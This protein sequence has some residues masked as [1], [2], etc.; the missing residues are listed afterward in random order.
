MSAG[1]AWEDECRAVSCPDQACKT[2]SC[3]RGECVEENK[4]DGIVRDGAVVGGTACDDGDSGTE[5]DV[6]SAGLLG[7]LALP[8]S[9]C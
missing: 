9:G 8:R 7:L 6:C 2:S 1:A 3:H 4:E 5:L